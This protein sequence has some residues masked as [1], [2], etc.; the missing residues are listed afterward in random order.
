M[1]SIISIKEVKDSLAIY[2][3]NDE[4]YLKILSDAGISEND[5]LA[6]YY[7]NDPRGE[8]EDLGIFESCLV[9]ALA[10]W[11]PRLYCCDWLLIW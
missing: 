1:K 6:G 9:A 2:K 10:I 4:L 11:S 5:L 8:G 7:K 3:K